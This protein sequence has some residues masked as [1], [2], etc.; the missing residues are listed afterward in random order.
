MRGL[1]LTAYGFS[2]LGDRGGAAALACF[3]IAVV[4]A[5]GAGLSLAVGLR[6]D[7]RVAEPVDSSVRVAIPA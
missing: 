4:L 5:L 7:R 3:I 2:V 1:L 6:A